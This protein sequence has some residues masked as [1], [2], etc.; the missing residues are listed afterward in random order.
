MARWSSIFFVA[1][2][3][4]AGCSG[5][6]ATGESKD[7]AELFDKLCTT[8]H[9]PNGQPTASMV[10]RLGVRDL[11][12]PELRAKITPDFVERQ[13]R[14]GSENKLMPGFEGVMTEEQLKLLAAY[15]AS[16]AFTQR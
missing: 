3:A 6:V 10:A 12:A 8:C 13:I 11:T 2:A 7:G 14:R 15:V 16:P 4:I 1:V 5:R 9:G